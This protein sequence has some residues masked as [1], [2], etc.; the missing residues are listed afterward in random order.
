MAFTAKDITIRCGKKDRAEDAFLAGLLHNIGQV[1][2]HGSD[3]GLYETIL[4]SA[5]ETQGRISDLEQHAFG[6]THRDVGGE[7]LKSWS[8]P[9]IYVD[10][11]REHALDNIT[12]PHKQLIIY[13]SL[14]DFLISNLSEFTF[15]GFIPYDQGVIE[16][17]HANQSPLESS[18]P[19]RNAV[20]EIYTKLI[21]EAEKTVE[22]E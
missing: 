3:P 22:K 10:A 18:E 13:V 5:I 21:T 7:I 8:F 4:S 11:A 12:S 17:D 15:L 20:L 16:V 14:A 6:T 1:A 19:V 2:L 9:D